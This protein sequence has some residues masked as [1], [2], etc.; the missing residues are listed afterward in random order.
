M[1][2]P[3]LRDYQIEGI[4]EAL[5]E[6]VAAPTK[7]RP[8]VL[9]VMGNPDNQGG[10]S[11]MIQSMLDSGLYDVTILAHTDMEAAPRICERNWDPLI[12]DEFSNMDTHMFDSL[13]VIS[14]VDV[15]EPKRVRKCYGPQVLTTSKGKRSK[16]ARQNRWR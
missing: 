16:L 7:E 15:G 14:E 13:T 6:E 5:A 4:R 11:R 10:K 3:E 2:Y 1:N 12:I 9:L 8:R